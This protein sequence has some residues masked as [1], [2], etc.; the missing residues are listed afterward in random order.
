METVRKGI[1]KFQREVYPQRKQQFADL[2]NTQKPETLFIT[3]SDSRVV[4]QL[5]TQSEP[6]QLFICRTAGNIVPTYGEVHGGVSATIEYAVAVLGVSDVIV[7]GHTNCGAMKGVLHPESVESLPAVRHWLRYGEAARHVVK[8]NYPDLPEELKLQVLTRE[9]LIAQLD[10]LR[11][12]PS[13]VARLRSG[14]LR[15][16]AMLYDIKTGEV[17]AYQRDAGFVPIDEYRYEDASDRS[18]TLSQMVGT[19]ASAGAIR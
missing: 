6:G 3:C 9:N 4:P 13:V 18:V 2:A 8:E 11:T 10:N 5:I 14:K 12:H 16:H 7:C 17:E 19:L 1:L 15:V